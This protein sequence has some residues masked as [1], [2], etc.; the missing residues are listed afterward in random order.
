MIKKARSKWNTADGK[1]FY[2][3]CNMQHFA[4]VFVIYYAAAFHTS[5]DD[6]SVWSVYSLSILVEHSDDFFNA[7]FGLRFLCHRDGEVRARTRWLHFFDS[8]HLFVA[9]RIVFGGL[10][11]VSGNMEPMV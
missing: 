7:Q 10:S 2:V 1:G 9:D 5:A 6:R 11:T 3:V 4:K 8:G